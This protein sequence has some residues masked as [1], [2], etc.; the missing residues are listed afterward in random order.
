VTPLPSWFWPAI[1]LWMVAAWAVTATWCVLGYR[2]KTRSTTTATT[3]P[4]EGN[5]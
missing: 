2:A 4:E 5:R 3:T 1:C